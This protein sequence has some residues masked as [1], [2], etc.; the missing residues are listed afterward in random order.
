MIIALA[1]RFSLLVARMISFRSVAKV[2]IAMCLVAGPYQLS[3]GASLPAGFADA[4]VAG[5]SDGDWIAP[6]GITFDAIGRTFIWERAGR[7]WFKD[8]QDTA[9]S[10]LIDISDEVGNW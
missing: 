5:P 2:I 1:R 3:W 6:V 4:E 10:L 7:V 8:P 9:F